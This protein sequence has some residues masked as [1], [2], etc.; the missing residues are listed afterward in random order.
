MTI[1]VNPGH[2]DGFPFSPTVDRNVPKIHGNRQMYL[3]GMVQDSIYDVMVLLL[4]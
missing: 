3:K 2:M 1:V 4:A